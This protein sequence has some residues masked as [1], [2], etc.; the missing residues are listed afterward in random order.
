MSE[1]EKVITIREETDIE[2]ILEELN[3]ILKKY[4]LTVI[5]CYGILE[6]LKVE[7]TESILGNED[8]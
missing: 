8:G 4:N 5:E 6:L 3:E 1:K 7:I 2:E